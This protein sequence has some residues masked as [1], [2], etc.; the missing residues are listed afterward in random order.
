MQLFTIVVIWDAETAFRGLILNAVNYKTA[1]I[2]LNEKYGD[3][4]LLIEEHLKSL[5]NL[6]IITNQWDLKRLEKFVSD[7]EINIRGLETLNTPPVVYQAALISI[8]KRN[9]CGMETP[10][11]KP[12]ERYV[13]LPVIPDDRITKSKSIN[14]SKERKEFFHFYPA[15]RLFHENSILQPYYK[16]RINLL[17]ENQPNTSAIKAVNPH[18][19][20]HHEQL[21]KLGRL[22]PE[23]PRR[24]MEIYDE[25]ASN[26]FT[27]LD[28]AAYFP[29][30]DQVL[31]TVYNRQARRYPRLDGWKDGQIGW[32]CSSLLS[33]Q[34]QNPNISCKRRFESDERTVTE[35]GSPLMYFKKYFTDEMFQ[36]IV[37]QSTTYAVQNNNLRV[38]FS[39][40]DIELFVGTLVKMGII[41]MSR[42]QMYWSANFRVNSIANWL[43]RNRF[44]ET[45]RYLHFN[46]NLQTIL[47][48]DDPNYDRLCKI[49]P[50]LEMFGKCCVETKNEEMQCVD[51]QIIAY[52]GKHKLKQY[53]PN[54]NLVH[55]GRVYNLKRTNMQDKQWVCRRVKK[56]CRGSIHTNLDVDAVLDC[57]PHADDC[58][59]D[60]DILYKM[61]KKA[62][63][64]RRAAE[65]MKT[66]PQ[67][68]HEEASSAS[69]DLETADFANS[70]AAGDSTPV[71]N[72]EV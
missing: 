64:K 55:E 27:S 5:Q 68:Y 40:H 61:E 18:A 1:L 45:M 42:Y 33:T 37:D 7:M 16:L 60:N 39:R 59:P 29:T 63:L 57:N 30:W 9:F 51:E 62:V 49:R 53:L 32:S 70:P 15:G 46:D 38:H 41:P 44:I 36:Y 28:T 58:I 69:A 4:Q 35:I 11:S 47:D 43:T 8:T 22:A 65:E 19:V 71:A 14:V 3:S 66:V 54:C 24:V 23:D 48:R 72:D 31:H 34:K 56:G 50:L 25:F 26:A 52:K 20:Y 10:K 17:S 6:P 13:C 21:D 67:I 12:S 2:I